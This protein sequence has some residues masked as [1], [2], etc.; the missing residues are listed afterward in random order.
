MDFFDQSTELARLIYLVVEHRIQLPTKLL[1]H[2]PFGSDLARAHSGLGSISDIDQV[3]PL[4]EEGR[5]AGEGSHREAAD[6]IFRLID[7]KIQHLSPQERLQLYQLIE[8]IA[9]G[10]L[11]MTAFEEIDLAEDYPIEPIAKFRSGF[12]PVDI[13]TDGLY[14]ALLILMGTPGTGKTSIMLSMMESL[15]QRGE[16]VWFFENEIPRNLMLSRT[17]PIRERLGPRE[18]SRIFCGPYDVVSIQEAIK[19]DPDPDRIIIFDS[20]DVYSGFKTGERRFDLEE[21]YRVLTAIKM[22]AKLV[23]VSSQPR[24][25]DTSL[26]MKSV[27]ESWAKAWYADMII[28]LERSGLGMLKA[29]CHKNRFG[30]SLRSIF[31][32]YDY[33]DMTW[34]V[35]N[36]DW[37]GVPG[38]GEEDW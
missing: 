25:G 17:S 29:E 8:T 11:S 14:Q 34:D 26:S 15:V 2:L 20:P 37:A 27:A 13:I 24:R 18:G 22:N 23:V 9:A 30:P 38:Q 28:G 31:F 35:Q 7:A 6:V 33:R 32:T 36:T 19:Q 3:L 4:Y 12:T 5:R 10:N 16:R 1:H 21:A